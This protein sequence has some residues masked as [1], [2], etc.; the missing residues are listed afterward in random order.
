MKAAQQLEDAAMDDRREK[1]ALNRQRG[2]SKNGSTKITQNLVAFVINH[3]TLSEA[4]SVRG[5]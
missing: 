3:T 4:P 5:F 1:A 2:F